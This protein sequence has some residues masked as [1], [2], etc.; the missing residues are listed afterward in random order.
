MR[1]ST[2][3]LT[4]SKPIAPNSQ[5][6]RTAAATCSNRKSSVRCQMLGHISVIHASTMAARTVPDR[7]DPTF[8]DGAQG[9]ELALQIVRDQAFL[10]DNIDQPA[11][12]ILLSIELPPAAVANYFQRALQRLEA[13]GICLPV[14]TVA[15]VLMSVSELLL[16]ILEVRCSQHGQRWPHDFLVNVVRVDPD[17]CRA[18]DLVANPVLSEAVV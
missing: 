18:L 3:C 17:H 4:A 5:A 13:P 14:S 15:V 7:R 16:C 11:C 10:K 6:W 2:K 9:T 8:Q 12:R 1:H